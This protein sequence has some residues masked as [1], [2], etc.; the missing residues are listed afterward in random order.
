MLLNLIWHAVEWLPILKKIGANTL[1]IECVTADNTKF[2]AACY[3]MKLWEFGARTMT[4]N[5]EINNK[6][7]ENK[8]GIGKIWHWN[9]CIVKICIGPE[10]NVT[11]KWITE[12]NISNFLLLFFFDINLLIFFFMSFPIIVYFVLQLF[13]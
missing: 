5:Y 3:S 12:I 2:C 11:R 7:T 8:R 4:V 9:T 10:K 13:A 6:I 1:F